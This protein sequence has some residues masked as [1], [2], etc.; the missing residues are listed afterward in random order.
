MILYCLKSRKIT[1]RKNPKVL[2]T[3]NGRILLSSQCVVYD[4]KKLRF[5]KQEEASRI[6]STIGL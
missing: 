4:D 5:I 1:K 2:V 3:K 6:L